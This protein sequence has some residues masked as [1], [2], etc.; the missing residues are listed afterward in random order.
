MKAYLES[1]EDVLK[2]QNTSQEGLTA[3]E[4]EKRLAEFGLNKLQE[5]KKK[6]LLQRFLGELTDP[7]I[8]ILIAAACIAAVVAGILLLWKARK[9]H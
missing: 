7:M 1:C 2:A 6:S 5:G 8:I 3:A 4:A 9:N